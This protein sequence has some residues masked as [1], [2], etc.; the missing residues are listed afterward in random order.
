MYC[1][2]L[3]QMFSDLPLGGRRR[4]RVRASW[5]PSAEEFGG[6]RMPSSLTNVSVART[7][8]ITAAPTVQPISSRVLPRIWAGT[9]PLRAL[10]LK[11]RVEQHA[12]DPDE[13]D[14][15][16]GEDE[17]VERVDV[18]GVRRAARLRRQEIRARDGGQEQG[19]RHDGEKG[20]DA[21]IGAKS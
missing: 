3:T 17:L 7:T 19:A 2:P 6:L 18:V 15:R 13:H 21:Q 20:E 10:N 16:D 11:T 9:A 14:E 1:W 12:L 8:R 4:R 5:R